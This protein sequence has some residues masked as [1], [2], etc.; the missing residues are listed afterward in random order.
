MQTVFRN[1][2]FLLAQAGVTDGLI[3]NHFNTG[4]LIVWESISEEIA[5]SHIVLNECFTNVDY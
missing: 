5:H 1:Q 4:Q 3:T 2:S